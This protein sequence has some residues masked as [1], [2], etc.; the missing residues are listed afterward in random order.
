MMMD[1]VKE[2]NENKKMLEK[3]NEP[4]TNS[5][6][7]HLPPSK[8]LGKKSKKTDENQ[9]GEKKPRGAPLGHPG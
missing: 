6:N 5:D 3:T 7:S 8:S 9:T 1:K 2:M 4:P